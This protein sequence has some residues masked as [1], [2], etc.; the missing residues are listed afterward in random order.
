ME[1]YICPHCGSKFCYDLHSEG[2]CNIDID[3]EDCGKKF[4]LVAYYETVIYTDAL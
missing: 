2:D 1:T 3:C 4:R